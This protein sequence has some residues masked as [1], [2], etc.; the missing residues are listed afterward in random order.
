MDPMSH[1]TS[2]SNEEGSR[3]NELLGG[4]SVSGKALCLEGF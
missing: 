4:T 2:A 3:E 1:H